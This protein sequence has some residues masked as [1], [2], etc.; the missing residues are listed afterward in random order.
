M[1]FLILLFSCS[2][3]AITP[4]YS[5]KVDADKHRF[6][7]NLAQYRCLVCQ[8]ESLLDSDAPLAIDLKN[9]IYQKILAGNSDSEIN[10]FLVQRYGSFIELNPGFNQH[11][12]YLWLLPCIAILIWL[13]RTMSS[14]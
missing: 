9:Q 2:L 6:E 13:R 5:F 14:L 12:I 7:Q 8:N 3:Y 4:I 1:R 11:T 10:Q